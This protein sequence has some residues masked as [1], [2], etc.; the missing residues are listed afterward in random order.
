MNFRAEVIAVGTELLLGN[1]ANTDAQFVSEILSS[2]GVDVLYHTTVGDNA[3]RLQAVTDIARRR[4]DLIIYIGGLGPTYDDVTKNVVSQAFGRALV[5]HPE[6]A[7][8]IRHC[9]EAVLHRPMS[10][11]NLQ[12]AYL[13][14]GC[15]IFPNPVGTAPG[16]CF[17]EDGVTVMMLPGVPHEC[18]HMAEHQVLPWLRRRSQQVILSRDIRIFGLTEP[19]VQELLAPLMNHA[20]NPSLA[21]YAKTGEVMLRMTA[22]AESE[23]ACG[24]LMSP[25]LREVRRLLGD[26]CYGENIPG[27]E[28]AVVSL[29]QE[30]QR[31]CAA[32][33]SC[34]GGLIAKRITDVPGASAVF[35]GGIVSYTNEVKAAL[36]GV[37]QSLLDTDGAVSEPVAAAMADGARRITGADLAVS[38]TG[39][40]GPGRDDRGNEVGTV[41]IG[42][43]TPAGTSVQHLRL[44]TGR[45]RVRILAAHHALDMI[46]RYLAGLKD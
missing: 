21:P 32:A 40:A 34:T 4:A 7:Q 43:S 42:L 9:F 44:G 15:E 20:V 14:T 11:C 22:K 26:Y 25:M 29:L 27:L 3:Q 41:F 39:V 37:P 46:R 38:V 17:T 36:L 10:A 24:A 2:A 5:F 28:Y 1:I 23:A 16:C 19:Q 8:Q 35:R 6:I 31:T 33:E 18:R 12:Q 45:E 30:K 13:P